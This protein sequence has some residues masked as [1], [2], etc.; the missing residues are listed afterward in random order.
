MK[1]MEVW[2]LV[3]ALSSQVLY[4]MAKVKTERLCPGICPPIAH[5]PS[6][7]GFP[8][9]GL[10]WLFCTSQ[11]C[12]PPC[13]MADWTKDRYP[14]C[15]SQLALIRKYHRMG[16][17]KNRNLFLIVLEARSP[18]S[19]YHLLQFLMRSLCQAYRSSHREDRGYQ[20]WDSLKP[21]HPQFHGCLTPPTLRDG[22]TG[23]SVLILEIRLPFPSAWTAD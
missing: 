13:T 11:L 19:R 22:P 20:P 23:E 21:P 15:L 1:G 4:S 7:G 8:A 12:L 17:L 14:S 18:R 10:W 6:K 16:G 2:F 9:V 5:S 3:R